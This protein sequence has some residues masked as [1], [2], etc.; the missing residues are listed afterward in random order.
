MRGL[1]G[2]RP[3]KKN[4]EKQSGAVRSF[5][6]KVGT[7]GLL[8]IPVS[9]LVFTLSTQ[10]LSA[11]RAEDSLKVP[12]IELKQ[13]TGKLPYARSEKLDTNQMR[14]RAEAVMDTIASRYPLLAANWRVGR[15]YERLPDTLEVSIEHDPPFNSIECEGKSVR[16]DVS[17][18]RSA[19][20]LNA[21]RPLLTDE[22][23]I[24]I[25][26]A[27]C[28]HNFFGEKTPFDVNNELVMGDLLASTLTDIPVRRDHKA[29]PDESA[30]F[31]FAKLVGPEE[32]LRAYAG[33]NTDKL[34]QAYDARFGAG[35]Y[36][37]LLQAPDKMRKII[38]HAKAVGM[39]RDK[40]AS[41]VKEQAKE[42][43]WTVQPGLW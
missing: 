9:A 8:L 7:S 17:T 21:D 10:R 36:E 43:G 37:Q 6:R 25:S 11:Q 34:R 26:Q 24:H 16:R 4:E 39:G 15:R 5:I 2:V 35:K 27:L 29:G 18:S 33:E 12:G 42:C 40:V 32:F 28:M 3:A 22:L 1:G 14:E 13:E 31:F 41:M 19:I 20:T 23:A 38:E 30:V